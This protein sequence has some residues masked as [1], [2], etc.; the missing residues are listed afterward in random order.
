MS[1][2]VPNDDILLETFLLNQVR[3]QLGVQ[4]HLLLKIALRPLH[5]L[6]ERAEELLVVR[7]A[8]QPREVIVVVVLT[9]WRL[10]E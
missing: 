10:A 4:A 7:S 3:S 5:L 1:K 9:D 6:L 2:V 8:E